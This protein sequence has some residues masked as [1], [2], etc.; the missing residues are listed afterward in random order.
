MM[1]FLCDMASQLS[2]AVTP[3]TR[4]RGRR[5]MER[6]T[7]IKVAGASLAGPTLTASSVSFRG[8]EQE[9]TSD[10]TAWKQHHR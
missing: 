1:A 2:F 3:V 6:V 7:A 5:H 8:Q 10:F 9:R 4:D